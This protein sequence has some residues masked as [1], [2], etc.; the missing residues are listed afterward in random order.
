MQPR[1][2]IPK[3]SK[4]PFV[5]RSEYTVIEHFHIVCSPSRIRGVGTI[6]VVENSFCNSCNLFLQ[7]FAKTNFANLQNPWFGLG[8]APLMSRYRGGVHKIIGTGHGNHHMAS[9]RTVLALR[10]FVIVICKI[11]KTNFEKWKVK[12]N[13]DQKK[14]HGVWLHHTLP[15]TW[16]FQGDWIR[17]TGA[18]ADRLFW[19]F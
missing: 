3:W 2:T 10:V 5:S 15:T 17:S 18:T 19:N 1:K 13:R 7:N 14:L 8:K 16:N 9:V 4:G 6:L 11:A 12:L